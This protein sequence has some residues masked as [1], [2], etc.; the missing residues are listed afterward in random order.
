MAGPPVRFALALLLALLPAAWEDYARAREG[1][2]ADPEASIALYRSLH[3]ADPDVAALAAFRMMALEPRR[4]GE[5]FQALAGHSPTQ[6]LL[7]A[8]LDLLIEAD[9]PRAAA[10]VARHR[11]RTSVQFR[12]SAENRL[13]EP[14]FL[15]GPRERSVLVREVMGGKSP[16]KKARLG[17]LCLDHGHP[18]SAHQWEEVFKAC[19]DARELETAEEVLG[20]IKAPPPPSWTY[21]IGRLRFLQRDYAAALPLF[22]A[23]TD[24]EEAALYQIGRCHLALGDLPAA[25]GAFGRVQG[26]LAPPAK[27]GVVRIFLME[28]SLAEALKTARSIG[29]K[30]MRR[31]ALL[32]CALGCAFAGEKARALG[33]LK[34]LGP[35]GETAYWISRLEGTIRP[36]LTSASAP[37]NALH[38]DPSPLVP[39]PAP[40]GGAPAPPPS[41]TFPRF[42]LARGLWEDAWLLSRKLPIEAGERAALA[43]RAGEHRKAM[44]LV[45]P[46]ASR[47][48]D[49]PVAAWDPAV[50]TG[51]FP[52]A[53]EPLVAKAAAQYGVP[54]EVIWSVMRQEST[55]NPSALSSAGAKGLMQLIP[56]TYGEYA[57]GVGTV[58]HAEENILSGTKYL[59][60]LHAQFGNWVCAVAAYNAGEDAVAA[61]LKVPA[62]LDL[63]AFYSL[64]PYSETKAYTRSVLYNMMLYRMLYPD[65]KPAPAG[66]TAN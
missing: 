49:G 50:L 61:W 14:R 23:A 2:A 53:F 3:A 56:P 66:G 38:L 19:L 33:I 39:R 34:E 31:N 63:P 4:A 41:S 55:F 20:R 44:N 37:F 36:D 13:L 18:L 51:F 24:R 12:R 43:H 65:L 26:E 59:A 45:Y 15:A 30:R 8:G 42:L 21:F 28:G 46:E 9:D 54:A 5:H 60:K 64:I 52:R 11:D 22:Q 62:T 16:F 6:E 7:E 32:S 17:R 58:W 57:N 27:L 10:L 48:L 47:M 35:D 29:A 40:P 25:R 1:E